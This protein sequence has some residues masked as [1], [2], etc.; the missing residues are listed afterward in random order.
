MLC[1]NC[2]KLICVQSKILQRIIV[3]AQRQRNGLGSYKVLQEKLQWYSTNSNSKISSHTSYSSDF[4]VDADSQSGDTFG[5]YAQQKGIKVFERLPESTKDV[6]EEEEIVSGKNEPFWYH[7]ECKKLA[8]LG[9]VDE[10]LE[11]LETQM[12]KKDKVKPQ[13]YNFAVVIGALGR[14]GD[15]NKAYNLYYKMKDYGL[16]PSLP[17]IT[18]LFNAVGNSTQA[19]DLVKVQKLQTELQEKNVRLHRNSYSAL[20][21]AYARHEGFQSTLQVFRQAIGNGFEPD[22]AYFSILLSSCKL[23]KKN[24]F[25]HAIQVW[26]TMTKLG[27]KPTG[28]VVTSFLQVVKCC[29][30]GDVDE[31]NRT[32]FQTSKPIVPDDYIRKYIRQFKWLKGQKSA[33]KP[34]NQTSDV[35]PLIESNTF[36]ISDSKFQSSVDLDFGASPV[37]ILSAP[38]KKSLNLLSE[39]GDNQTVVSITSCPNPEDRLLLVGGYRNFL[40]LLK[41][42][43]IPGNVKIFTTLAEIMPDSYE[44][45]NHLISVAEKS[46]CELDVDFY[47]CIMRKRFKRKSD[48]EGKEIWDHILNKKLQ[49]N[50]RSWCVYALS[51]KHFKEGKNFLSDLESNKVTPNALMMHTLIIGALKHRRKWDIPGS[52]EIFCPDYAYLSF[53]MSHM[54]NKGVLVNLDIVSAL[55]TA[56]ATPRGYQKWSKPNPKLEKVIKSFREFYNKWLTEIHIKD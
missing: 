30:I 24:G 52:E 45:E 10:C 16:K 5:S 22:A 43:E 26:K 8:K 53:L 38:N 11:M 9:K 20:M 14:V 3:H 4:Q 25:L 35:P 17:C 18:S 6:A 27:I 40:Q 37:S 33:P 19:R 48:I 50:F 23:D 56:A 28:H 7:Y 32:L 54:K 12:L 39:S 36:Q 44:D 46:K 42:H 31:A 49:P 41:Q 34:Q 15:V 1:P 29:E 51:V 2:V 55:E 13:N 47:N 21:K